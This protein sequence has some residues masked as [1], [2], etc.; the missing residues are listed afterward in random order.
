MKSASTLVLLENIAA[1]Q[2]GIF[3]AKQAERERIPNW[4]LIRLL[5]EQRLTRARRG[6]YLLPSF[7]S[8]AHSDLRIAWISLV[9]HKFL[10]ERWIECNKVAVSHES[11]A[12]VH[13]LG[14][15]TAKLFSFSAQ[16]RKQ[17]TQTDIRIYNPISL[18]DSDVVSI[19]GLP[20]TSVERTVQDLA[21]RN[22]D[23]ESLAKCI[24][25]ALRKE[26]V[27][28]ESLGKRLD[29]VAMAYKYKSGADLIDAVLMENATD[30]DLEASWERLRCCLEAFT[31]LAQRPLVQ[32]L[33]EAENSDSAEAVLSPLELLWSDRGK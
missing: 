33:L 30:E 1:Q 26:E 21:D 31:R 5:N 22:M 24:V 9:P 19:D 32:E 6:V 13:G 28:L 27:N 14:D 11:A 3:T 4:W 18:P 23:F 20:V 7:S 16:V 10:E 8:D 25:D 15:V 17:C 29:S 2:W 12:E